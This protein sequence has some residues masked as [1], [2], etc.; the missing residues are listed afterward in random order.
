MFQVGAP[1]TWLDPHLTAASDS[2]PQHIH[3]QRIRAFKPSSG[4]R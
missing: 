4:S 2:W 3:I 1:G